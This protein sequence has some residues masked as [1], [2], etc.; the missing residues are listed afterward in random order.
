MYTANRVQLPAAAVDITIKDPLGNVLATQY[1][2]NED[3]RTIQSRGRRVRQNTRT[4]CWFTRT[5]ELPADAN[6]VQPA[7]EDSIVLVEAACPR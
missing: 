4:G 1:H 6:E 5:L 2:T 3:E 7:A